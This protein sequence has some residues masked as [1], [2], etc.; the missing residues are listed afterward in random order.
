MNLTVHDILLRPVI[1]EHTTGLTEKGNKYTFRVHKRANKL[2]IRRAVEELFNVKVKKV[3]TCVVPPKRKGG[4][5]A[6]R[7][8][9][10]SAWKKA[11][12]TVA[13]G[14]TIDLV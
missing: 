11:I 5:R 7:P 9:F 2:Q 14:D 10:T 3:R 13:A 6:R 8:G 1:T 12:V 4:L